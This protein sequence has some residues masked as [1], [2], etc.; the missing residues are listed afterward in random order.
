M[1]TF[2]GEVQCMGM[3]ARSI[4][5]PAFCTFLYSNKLKNFARAYCGVL[6]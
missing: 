5:Y 6:Q 4:Q 2:L 1:M 3:L